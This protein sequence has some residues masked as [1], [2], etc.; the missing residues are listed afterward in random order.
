MVAVLAGVFIH[1]QRNNRFVPRRV[2]VFVTRDLL[3]DGNGQFLSGRMLLY[4]LNPLNRP[5][6]GIM[7]GDDFVGVDGR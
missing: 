5:Y 1:W 3:G 6:E 2:A 7:R 4:D